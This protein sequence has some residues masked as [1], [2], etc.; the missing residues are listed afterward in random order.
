MTTFCSF[1]NFQTFFLSY[2]FFHPPPF[3]LFWFVLWPL[4]IISLLLFMWIL[5]VFNAFKN[6]FLNV[7]CFFYEDF[8]LFIFCISKSKTG[9]HRLLFTCIILGIHVK[10]QTMTGSFLLFFSG[11]SGS[12]A[13]RRS[14]CKSVRNSKKEEN[15]VTFE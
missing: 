10:K 1:L 4:A 5:F 11:C 7:N 3:G 14:F 12:D 9:E 13:N 6:S 15:G 8:L 2:P